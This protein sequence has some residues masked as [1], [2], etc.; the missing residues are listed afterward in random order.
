MNILNGEDY[1]DSSS[2]EEDVLAER[3]RVLNLLTGTEVRD[4]SVV[5]VKVLIERKQ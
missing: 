2:M 5:I 4:N 3:N 1:E